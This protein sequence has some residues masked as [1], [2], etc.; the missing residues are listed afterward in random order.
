ME[1]DWGDHRAAAAAD[2]AADDDE[3]D[4]DDDDDGDA[5]GD[6]GWTQQD[7]RLPR[8]ERTRADPRPPDTAETRPCTDALRHCPDN[9]PTMNPEMTG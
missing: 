8:T 4:D 2:A 9:V 5:G 1:Y 7:R 6:A 3:D